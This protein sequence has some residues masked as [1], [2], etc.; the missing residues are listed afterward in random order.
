MAKGGAFF[1][2]SWGR[3]V[4]GAREYAL[5]D[6]SSLIADRLPINLFLCAICNSWQSNQAQE[7]DLLGNHARPNRGLQL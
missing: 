4:F 1:S 6:S 5:I 2:L 7:S 3:G